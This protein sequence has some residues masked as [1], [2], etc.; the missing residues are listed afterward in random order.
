MSTADSSVFIDKPGIIIALYV[1]DIFIF[2]R[3]TKRIEGTKC[4]LK[5][6]YPMKDYGLVTKILG[7]RV[8]WHD[9]GIKLDQEIYAQ[10]ILEEFAMQDCKAKET[11]MVH[12]MQTQFDDDIIPELDKKEHRLYRRL[13]G[14]LMFLATATRPDISYAV[15]WLAQYLATPRTIHLQAAK[16][17][18]RY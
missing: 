18:L 10:Q 11:P 13:I 9:E 3:D 14:R 7:I 17:V 4:Q 8:T 16:H 5:T 2:G 1:D 12:D 6:F 15:N